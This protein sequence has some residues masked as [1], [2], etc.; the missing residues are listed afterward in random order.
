MPG[1]SA[2][3]PRLS[4]EILGEH[5]AK[6]VEEIQTTPALKRKYFVSYMDIKLRDI[7]P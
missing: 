2:I 6:L 4:D 1:M 7:Y 3:N 5:A